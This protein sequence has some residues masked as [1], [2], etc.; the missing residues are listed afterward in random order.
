MSDTDAV[1]VSQLKGFTTG[2]VQYDKNADGSNNTNSLTFNPDGSGQTALHNVGAGV[3]PTDAVNV[4]QLKSGLSEAVTTANSYTD[5]RIAAIQNDAWNL[6]G[7]VRRLERDMHAGIAT[8]IALKAAPFVA[9]RT[10]YYAGVG[11]Y[12]SQAAVGISLRRTADSGRWSVEG[13]ASTN[14]EGTGV[15]LGF[16]GVLG[17]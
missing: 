14:R 5:G 11:G 2:G 16:S 12:R 3:A 6:R 13:G 7:D 8:A 4:G 15:Y 10:T 17:D 1:N 9:G